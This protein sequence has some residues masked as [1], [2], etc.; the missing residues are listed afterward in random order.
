MMAGKGVAIRAF[1]LEISN[2][3]IDWNNLEISTWKSNI[4]SSYISLGL[5]SNSFVFG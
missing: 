1:H 4:A 5:L 2:L 3:D